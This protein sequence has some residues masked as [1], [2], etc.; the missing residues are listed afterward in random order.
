MAPH[1]GPQP[2]PQLPGAQATS[3]NATP[4]YARQ[5]ISTEN[6]GSSRRVTKDLEHE[7]QA[8]IYTYTHTGRNRAGSRN[9]PEYFKTIMIFKSIQED[10]AFIE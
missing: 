3:D 6:K 2:D 8:K 1:Q 7:S 9:K 4:C 5:E 10:T